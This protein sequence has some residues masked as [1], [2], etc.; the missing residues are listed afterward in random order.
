MHSVGPGYPYSWEEHTEDLSVPFVFR[1]FYLKKIQAEMNTPSNEFSYLC[2]SVSRL[3]KYGAQ[4][5]GALG[6]C[7]AAVLHRQALL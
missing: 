3:A 7:P 1:F 2:L 6:K 4:V 5:L